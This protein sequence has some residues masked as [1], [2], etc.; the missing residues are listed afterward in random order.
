M[1]KLVRASTK[2]GLCRAVHHSFEPCPVPDNFFNSTDY[3]V[4]T[5][6]VCYFIQ[7]IRVTNR[8]LDK[9]KT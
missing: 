2:T 5:L 1:A 4:R 7:Y 3:L 9:K 6:L 8:S